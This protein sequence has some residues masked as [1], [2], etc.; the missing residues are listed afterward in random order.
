MRVTRNNTL[1]VIVDVQERLHPLMYNA[2]HVLTKAT[3]LIRGLTVLDIPILITEQ[4]PKGLGTTVEPIREALGDRFNPIV[5]SAFSCC[6]ER[7][8]S[9]RLTEH[10]RRT[11]LIAGIESHV[12]VLQTSLDLLDADYDPVVVLDATSS[13]SA[14]DQEIA[15][16]RI[17]REGGRIT[18]VESI[19]F[20][21]ARVSGTDQFKSISKLVK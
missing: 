7:D 3:T 15:A 4:Y 17:E 8:F 18:S 20:E 16:R 21:I 1:A 19:L 12:C 2:D 6:D 13:R 11:V 10:G 14:R 9:R 5:K